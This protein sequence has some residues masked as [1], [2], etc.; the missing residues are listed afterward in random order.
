MSEQQQQQ[1]QQ[2][3]QGPGNTCEAQNEG[4]RTIRLQQQGC[5][6]I[7]AQGLLHSSCSL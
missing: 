3:L 5:R 2:V 6:A 1:Q 7:R 4:P